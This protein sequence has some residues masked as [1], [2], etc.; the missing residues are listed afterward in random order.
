MTGKLICYRL[1]TI[2]IAEEC[3]I[4]KLRGI[5]KNAEMYGRYT[6]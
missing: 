3:Y 5:A 2:I 4:A 6:A 1:K